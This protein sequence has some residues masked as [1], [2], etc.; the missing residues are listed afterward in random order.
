MQSEAVKLILHILH[1]EGRT[2]LRCDV[3]NLEM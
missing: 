3:L 2:E 1:S